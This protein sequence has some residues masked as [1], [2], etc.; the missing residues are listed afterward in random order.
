MS[1]AKVGC[2][3]SQFGVGQN[4]GLYRTTRHAFK[5]Q[6]QYSTKVRIC[7]DALAIKHVMGSSYALSMISSPVL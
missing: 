1:L 2:M 4:T 7:E 6:F 5:I 3:I